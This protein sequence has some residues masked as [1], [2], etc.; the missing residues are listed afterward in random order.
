MAVTYVPI[1]L[2]GSIKFGASASTNTDYSCW[3]TQLRIVQARELIEVPATFCDAIT[4][5]V[6]GTRSETVE[7]TYMN[8]L[9]S[10]SLWV[11]LWD[12]YQTETAEL[13]FEAK[14]REGAVSNTNP[15]FYGT[16]LVAGLSTGG[17]VGELSTDAQ[18]FPVK[19]Q[20]TKATS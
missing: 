17:V 13:Y 4:S 12:A 15:R 19:G 10:S 2:K 20:T 8:E 9:S 16:M 6:P 5:Q 14:F 3:V 18:T 1:V 7:L 11:T